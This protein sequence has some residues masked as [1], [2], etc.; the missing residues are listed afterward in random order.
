MPPILMEDDKKG[1][2]KTLV[3]CSYLGPTRIYHPKD[4][5]AIIYHSVVLKIK[6]VKTESTLQD[7]PEELG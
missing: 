2:W 5:L 1:A 3:I 4:N 7:L 6:W